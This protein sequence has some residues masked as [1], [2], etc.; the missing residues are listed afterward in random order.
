VT[1]SSFSK[2]AE[3]TAGYMSKRIVLID[4]DRLASLMIRYNVGCRIKETLYLKDVDE[5]F[6]LE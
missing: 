4:G 1:T 6:F 3:E 2:D 5:D